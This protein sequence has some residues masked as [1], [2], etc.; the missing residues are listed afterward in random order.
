[1]PSLAQ[2]PYALQIRKRA[3]FNICLYS[4][5]KIYHLILCRLKMFHVI[6]KW[7]SNARQQKL[8]VEKDFRTFVCYIEHFSKEDGGT[9]E[10]NFTAPYSAITDFMFRLYVDTNNFNTVTRSNEYVVQ[11]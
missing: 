2:S 6:S 9:K 3:R 5:I 4:Y 1:M 11:P 10:K 8:L 7:F